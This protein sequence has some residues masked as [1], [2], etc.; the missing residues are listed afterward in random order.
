M[1]TTRNK[2]NAANLEAGQ[3]ALEALDIMETEGLRSDDPELDGHWD[4][5]AR[6]QEEVAYLRSQL[7]VAQ[8]WRQVWPEGAE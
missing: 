8:D 3:L 5:L 4:S 1:S 2:M 6:R 7:P